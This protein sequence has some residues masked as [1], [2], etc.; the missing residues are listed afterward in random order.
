M[1]L[2]DLLMSYDTIYYKFLLMLSTKNLQEMFLTKFPKE[3]IKFAMYTNYINRYKRSLMNKVRTSFIQF[4]N[5]RQ[6]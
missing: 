5:Q 1:H 6:N 3:A 4:R 2:L